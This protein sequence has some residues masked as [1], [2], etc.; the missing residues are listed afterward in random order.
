MRLEWGFKMDRKYI[1]LRHKHKILSLLYHGNR[2]LHA[3]AEA[4]HGNLLGNMYIAKVKNVVKNINAAFVEIKPGCP[5][6]LSLNGLKNPL[7][8]NRDYDGRVLDGDEILVQVY[9]E[10]TKSK[11]PT[12]T[13]SLSLDG[14]YCVASAR[15][16][17]VSYSAKLSDKV[18][19]R[20][21]DCLEQEGFLETYGREAGIIIRTN[22]KDLTEDLTP[23]K[24]EIRTLTG[25]LHH[26]MEIARHRTCYSVLFEQLPAYLTGIRDEYEGQYEEIVTDQPDIYETVLA[27]RKKNPSFPIPGVRLYQDE[28]VPLYKLYSVET[29]LKEAL[30]KKV[31]LKS[32]GY[33]VIEHTEALTAIDVNTGK[34]TAG[35]DMEETYL[36]TNLEAAGE[37]AVQMAL[38]NLSG[39]ILVD[40]INMSRE[41]NNKRLMAFFGD[42]LKKDPVRTQLIDI[43]A[44]GL[45]EITRMKMSKPLQEQLIF[46]PDKES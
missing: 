42:L 35:K 39:M 32:G 27:Y 7:I 14:K 13:C 24:D 22:A 5:C 11:T 36:R 15:R 29:R 10:E 30:N 19:K 31:W 45:V 37:I 38:R 44:L 25:K 41:E 2:L 9:K 8:T 21:G 6:F 20:I 40:F 3:R 28:K 4:E 33:L 23:L 16:L 46:Q 43:T 18:K 12:V 17:G 1:I 26:I 34:L